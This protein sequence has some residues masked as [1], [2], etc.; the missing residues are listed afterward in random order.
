V[1]FQTAEIHVDVVGLSRREA[2][3]TTR[4]VRARRRVALAL[5]GEAADRREGR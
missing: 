2:T 5:H 4:L 1:E 3:I